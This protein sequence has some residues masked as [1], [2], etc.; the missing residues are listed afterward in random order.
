VQRTTHRR[1]RLAVALV[2]AVALVGALATP[3]YADIGGTYDPATDTTNLNP[4]FP[5]DITLVVIGGNLVLSPAEDETQESGACVDFGLEELC[6]LA[7]GEPDP[8]AQPISLTGTI[9]QDGTLTVPSTGVFFPSADPIWADAVNAWVFATVAAPAGVSGTIDPETGAIVLD[10]GLTFALTFVSTAGGETEMPSDPSEGTVTGLCTL[11]VPAVGTHDAPSV[12]APHDALA[13]EFP[14]GEAYN[15]SAGIG[16]AV[17]PAFSTAAFVGGTGTDVGTCDS[18]FL[19]GA[20]NSALRLP[21]NSNYL[22]MQ[23]VSDPVLLPP[24]TPTVTVDAVT[25]DAAGLDPAQV[26]TNAGR[27]GNWVQL[28]GPFWTGPATADVALCDVGGG[29][30][31]AIGTADIDAGGNLSGSAEIT[32]ANTTGNRE[33][34]VTSGAESDSTPFLVLGDVTASAPGSGPAGGTVNVSGTNWNPLSPS[35]VVT[36]IDELNNPLSVTFTEPN[37]AGG[38]SQNVQIVV[39]TVAIVV[40]ETGLGYP[41]PQTDPLNALI[42]VIPFTIADNEILCDDSPLV[43]LSDG[44][45]DCALEQ[46]VIQEIE[47]GVFTFGQVGAVI[48]MTPITLDGT[49][50]ITNGALNQLYWVDARGTNAGWAI[51]IKMTDLTN[52]ADPGSIPASNMTFDPS[53]AIVDAAETLTLTVATGGPLGNDYQA[54][55]SAAACDSGGSFTGDAALALEV[56]AS[57]YAGTYTATITIQAT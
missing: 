38:I 48:N 43:N 32:G 7:E 49:T 57:A 30:C 31:E 50:Q 13:T 46:Q 10:L 26:V 17:D 5:L 15:P 20:M 16:R 54:F 9:E 39:G 34:T 3:A 14:G 47:G 24:P 4:T 6:A 19:A 33:L 52:P 1:G 2:A 56:P 36:L 35:T 27:A 40:A 11:G 41:D 42:A 12:A 21:N 22:G 37:A 44:V 28:S 29:N 51:T 23:F 8:E 45:S 25:H 53:C 18:A 55:C